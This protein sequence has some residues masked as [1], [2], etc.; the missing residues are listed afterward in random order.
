MMLL[1][2]AGAAVTTLASLIQMAAIAIRAH[3]VMRPRPGKREARV[4][5][6]VMVRFIFWIPP[7]CLTDTV[8]SRAF[9]DV[10]ETDPPRFHMPCSICES[11]LSVFACTLVPEDS[12]D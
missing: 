11:L 8:V 7:Q 2:V 1:M 3:P 10:R 5:P 4:A 6:G 9:G 12:V